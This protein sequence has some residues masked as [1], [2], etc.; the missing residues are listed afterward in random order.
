MSETQIQLSNIHRKSALRRDYRRSVQQNEAFWVDFREKKKDENIFQKM[1]SF[2]VG[3]IGGVIGFTTGG[4]PGAKA[5]FSWGSSL[6]KIGYLADNRKFDA[7]EH[8]YK[9]KKSAIGKFNT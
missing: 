8:L 4:L 2:G 3:I 6:A 1:L 5:G 7:E 9:N